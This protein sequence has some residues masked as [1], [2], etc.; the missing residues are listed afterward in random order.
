M[1]DIRVLTPNDSLFKV[2]REKS[3]V[4]N[5]G[6]KP[7]KIAKA[8]ETHIVFQYNI[9]QYHGHVFKLE[10][11]SLVHSQERRIKLISAGEAKEVVILSFPTVG[12]Y[13]LRMNCCLVKARKQGSVQQRFGVETRK[14]INIKVE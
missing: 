1:V 8:D 13:L 12:N 2:K 10:E 4:L 9:L 3:I 7:S 6:L 11:G 5:L 14:Y